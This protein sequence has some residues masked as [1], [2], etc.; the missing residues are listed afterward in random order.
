MEEPARDH[1]AVGG[2]AAFDG[3]SNHVAQRDAIKRALPLFFHL[4][5]KSGND[6]L[7]V[8]LCAHADARQEVDVVV[9]RAQKHWERHG[10]EVGALHIDEGAGERF[11]TKI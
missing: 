3:Q 7:A 11:D 9:F 5:L 4:P 8:V 2:S 10:G 1:D 6:D